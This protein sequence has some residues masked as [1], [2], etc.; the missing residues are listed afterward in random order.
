VLEIL[1]AELDTALGLAGSPRASEL[2]RSFLTAA[3][4]SA[5]GR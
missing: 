5:G 1:L 3:P 2:D 4:W